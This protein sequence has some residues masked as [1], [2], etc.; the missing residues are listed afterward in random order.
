MGLY[1]RERQLSILCGISLCLCITTIAGITV[2]WVHWKD[3]LNTCIDF[4]CECIL[5]GTDYLNVFTGGKPSLCYFTTFASVPVLI[6]AVFL[7][8][9]HGYRVC[10]NG[11]KAA[12]KPRR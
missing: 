1:E 8:G 11:R 7:A 12:R 3:I 9:Y 4:S 6:I 2:P 5:Y 10:M